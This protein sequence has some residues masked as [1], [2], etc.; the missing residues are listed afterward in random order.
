M[1]DGFL[2]FL[3]VG[4][5]RRWN[6]QACK[7]GRSP[8]SW[9]LQ[10][11]T[12]KY[13]S[14][15][16][17]H[18]HIIQRALHRVMPFCHLSKVRLAL[19]TIANV[20]RPRPDPTE[21]R[22]ALYANHVQSAYKNDAEDHLRSQCHH[23]LQCVRGCDQIK[24]TPEELLLVMW[25]HMTPSGK[26]L[27]GNDAGP[28][29]EKHALWNW[30]RTVR[31][32][33][34]LQNINNHAVCIWLQRTERSKHETSVLGW[35]RLVCQDQVQHTVNWLHFKTG[36]GG[37]DMMYY[38]AISLRLYWPG[39]KEDLTGA[40]HSCSVCRL[41][42]NFIYRLPLNNI[43]DSE[44]LQ[45]GIIDVTYL[46][47]YDD[48]DEDGHHCWQYLIVMVDHFTKM[49]WAKPAEHR[50]AATIGSSFR[51]TTV[52]TYNFSKRTLKD[53]K[54]QMEEHEEARKEEREREEAA[55][56]EEEARRR[57]FL[58]G[59]K[60]QFPPQDDPASKRQRKE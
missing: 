39:M 27:E 2:L 45:R 51:S 31:E 23:G 32:K 22:S 3:D 60:K 35:F 49:A 55:R 8:V 50:N 9:N 18:S 53:F 25:R 41:K 47:P 42:V 57:P 19:N 14:I 44:P 43:I 24:N 1:H 21:V 5:C 15:S 58:F 17:A 36:H 7:S 11:S 6:L 13:R 34:M 37:R 52:T 28:Q 54:K 56:R 38:M 12:T 20:I 4:K 40:G 46:P 33:T 29:R 48:Q 59:R 26:K 16:A 30:T 10:A